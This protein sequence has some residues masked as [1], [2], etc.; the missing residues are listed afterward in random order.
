MKSSHTTKLRSWGVVVMTMLLALVLAACASKPADTGTTTEPEAAAVEPV[1]VRV[2]SL[3]GPTSIGLASFMGNVDSLGLNNTYTFNIA[4]AADE[5]LPSVIKGETDIALVPANVAA[6]LYNKT[7]GGVS[8]IDINT[9][10]VLNVVTGDASVQQFADLAGKTVYMTGKGAT[11]EYAMN[12]LLGKAGIA[13]QVTLEFK[14]EPTEVVQA[15]SADATAVGVLPQPFATAACIKNEAL[16]AV[17]DLTDVWAATVDDGSQF[18]TGVTVVRNDFL[19]EHP[20]AVQEFITQQAAS[21]DAANG[22]P[23]AVAPLVVQAGIIDAEG[24][25]AKAIP[26]C[27]LVCITGEDMKTAL[28]GYLQTLFDSDPTSVGGTLP[29]DDFYWLG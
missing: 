29:A 10:G 6:V 4:T 24:V 28:S 25:A 27:H 22:D 18:L 5:I 20:E 21:V 16:K 7:E 26:G 23:A 1:E 17:I 3:K 14:S 9:L 19:A 15:L 11:P 8:V 12:F 13:D 2:A